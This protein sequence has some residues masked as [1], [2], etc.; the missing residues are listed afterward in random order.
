MKTKQEVF[1]MLEV[2][3]IAHAKKVVYKGTDCGA[4][5]E[6]YWWGVSMGS[7]VEGSDSE[8][9]VYMLKYKDD[10]SKEDFWGALDRIDI[11]GLNRLLSSVS[12]IVNELVNRL[13]EERS[14]E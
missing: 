6:F 10:F 8:T 12:A 4:W 7:I 3:S 11:E 2:N 5:I 1:D 13:L 9:S 14:H